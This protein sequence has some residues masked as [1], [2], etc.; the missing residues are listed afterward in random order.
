MGIEDQ[1]RSGEVW[2]EVEKFAACGRGGGRGVE[3]GEEKEAIKM[4]MELSRGER[5]TSHEHVG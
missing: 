1:A 5:W 3:G 4:R 2:D